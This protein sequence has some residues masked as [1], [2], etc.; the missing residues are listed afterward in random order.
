[1]CAKFVTCV[2]KKT[3]LRRFTR[4]VLLAAYPQTQRRKTHNT[5]IR[6]TTRKRLSARTGRSF[7]TLYALW[8]RSGRVLGPARCSLLLMPLGELDD[9]H[10]MYNAISS[11][12]SAL[13]HSP[14]CLSQRLALRIVLDGRED[15]ELHM[16]VLCPKFRVG[17]EHERVYRGHDFRSRASTASPA[18]TGGP[19]LPRVLGAMAST[20]LGLRKGEVRIKPQTLYIYRVA[21]IVWLMRMRAYYILHTFEGD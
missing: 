12:A 18:R 7:W 19:A 10:A 17:S 16:L 4:L 1:M 8:H 21:Y 3:L 20:G 5:R 6:H 9:V 14:V 2:G 11:R 13:A 15:V